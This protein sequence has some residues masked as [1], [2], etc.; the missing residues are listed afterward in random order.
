MPRSGAVDVWVADLSGVPESLLDVLCPQ[1]RERAS[2]LLDDR[3][4]ADWRASRA[5]LRDLLGRATGRDPETLRFAIGSYGKPKL[6]CFPNGAPHFNLSHSGSLAI[7]ALCPDREV[8]VDVEIVDRGRATARDEVA[9]AR[10]MLGAQVAA[11]LAG[12]DADRRHREFLAAW[13]AHEARVKCLGVGIGE[14]Q[15]CQ[16]QAQARPG[17]WVTALSVGEQALAALAVHG[18]RAIVRVRRWERL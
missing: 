12:L 7:Y 15:D 3:A 6:E 9:I 14:A 4:R 16:Q 10:R 8:G 17:L 5:V 11:R 13:V 2:R 1:E 18:G